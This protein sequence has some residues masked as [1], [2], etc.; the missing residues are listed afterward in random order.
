VTTADDGDGDGDDFTVDGADVDVGAEGGDFIDLLDFNL[1]ENTDIARARGR[2]VRS[3][4]SGA[5]RT[6]RLEL[7]YAHT[8]SHDT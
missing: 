4:V 2:E 3:D 5:R 6:L 1:R 8:L 7:Q